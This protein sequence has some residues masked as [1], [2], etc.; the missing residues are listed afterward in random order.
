M[1]IDATATDRLLKVSEVAEQLR[2]SPTSIYRYIAR[3]ELPA[4]KLSNSP[5]ASLR[6]SESELHAWLFVNEKEIG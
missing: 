6:V 5:R 1:T 3:G 4:I 2:V